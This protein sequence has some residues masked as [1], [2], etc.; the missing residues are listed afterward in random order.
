MIKKLQ[1][2]LVLV[3]IF[4]A[5]WTWAQG[6]QK[7]LIFSGFIVDGNNADPLPGVHLYIPQVGRGTSTDRDGFFIIPTY[8][9]DSLI[10]SSIGYKRRYYLVPEEKQESF[11]VVIE[12]V[13]DTTMLPILEIFPYPT[14]ELFK[15][16]FLALELPD[17]EKIQNMR[18]NLN[19]RI[20]TRLAYSM[21]MDQNMN[22]D[23]YAR[24]DAANLGN[25]FFN[26][27][28]QILNPF[29]WAEFIRSVKRGDFK[30][31]KWKDR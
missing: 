8:A 5:E 23:Y 7:V 25:R 20:M 31:G 1:I 19:Q 16:A 18:K 2:I 12:L 13:S 28:L 22:F 24:Q 9:G 6:E 4:S 3:L 17:E 30:R 27:T 10:I 26:P 21:E 15:E 14:E 29:A 11:S